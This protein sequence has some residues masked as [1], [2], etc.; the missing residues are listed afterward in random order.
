MPAIPKDHWDYTI[1]EWTNNPFIELT[2]ALPEKVKVLFDVGA[3][4]GGFSY[5]M[6]QKYPDVKLYCFEPV[7]INYDALIE[8]LPE[9]N[10]MK[11]GIYYGARESKVISRSGNI[12]AFF[13]EQIDTNFPK[14][15]TGEIIQLR[16]LEELDLP[17]PDLIKLDVECA[18]DNIIIHSR[19][20]KECPNVIV[21]WHINKE[22]LQ[23]FKQNM[24]NHKIK[25]NLQNMQFLLCQN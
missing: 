16:E 21:E 2:Q 4:V 15:S 6:K 18:E 1:R 13:I 11:I 22:P 7:A 9:A 25:V 8:Y 3:N 17:K 10:S 20:I 5:V 14:E 23:F 24:P 19:I 12:G